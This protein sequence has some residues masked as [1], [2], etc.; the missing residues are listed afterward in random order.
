MKS[1][2]EKAAKRELRSIP[3]NW[4]KAIIE[5]ILD[6]EDDPT[7]SG[8]LELTGYPNYYRIKVGYYRVVYRLGHN[9]LVVRRIRKRSDETYRGLNPQD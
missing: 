4:Q 8:S 5:A 1:R 7:P 9:A 3:S 6:L 2:I